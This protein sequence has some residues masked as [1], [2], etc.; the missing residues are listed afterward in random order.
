MTQYTIIHNSKYPSLIAIEATTALSDIA[1][2]KDWRVLLSDL[3][4]AEIEAGLTNTSMTL[5]YTSYLDFYLDYLVDDEL[6]EEDTAYIE[7]CMGQ[8]FY[9]D[10]KFEQAD[11]EE[12]NHEFHFMEAPTCEDTEFNNE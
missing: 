10:N 11:E 8:P 4:Q 12:I 3:T 2:E 9:D 6:T 1:F 5:I 7:S